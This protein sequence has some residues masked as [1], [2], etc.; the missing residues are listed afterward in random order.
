MAAMLRI[1]ALFSLIAIMANLVYG[2]ANNVP[3]PAY[4][5]CLRKNYDK[6]CKSSDKQS[7]G[8]R[9]GTSCLGV[10]K[11][12]RKTDSIDAIVGLRKKSVR[13]CLNQNCPIQNVP[14][15]E[16]VYSCLLGCDHQ[17]FC[18]KGIGFP[19]ESN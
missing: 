2:C 11:A 16:A 5:S 7:C 4:D 14:V 8:I 1:L 3:T 17:F 13:S 6:L 10:A 15:H 12:F 19:Q 18:D 9:V